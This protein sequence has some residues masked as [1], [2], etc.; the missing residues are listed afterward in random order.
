MQRPEEC[1]LIPVEYIVG[2]A[3]LVIVMTIGMG[4]AKAEAMKIMVK[5][6]RAA[7]IS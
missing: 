4:D 2:P 1:L 3:E 7:L 6:L 5:N